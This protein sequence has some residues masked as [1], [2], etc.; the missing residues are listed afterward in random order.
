MISQLL[1]NLI[2]TD[3]ALLRHDGSINQNAAARA[4]GIHQPTLF[5]ILSDQTLE[6]KAKAVDAICEYFGIEPSQLRGEWPI[7]AITNHLSIS[8]PRLAKS[9][10]LLLSLYR[11]LTPTSQKAAIRIMAVLKE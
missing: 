7:P 2:R 5:H 10:E 8:Q 11:S 9:G 6:P 3:A 4:F 1:E